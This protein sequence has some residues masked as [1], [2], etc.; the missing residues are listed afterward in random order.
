MI[1]GRAGTGAEARG[2]RP[3]ARLLVEQVEV[4]A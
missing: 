1:S 4:A 2:M 3:V